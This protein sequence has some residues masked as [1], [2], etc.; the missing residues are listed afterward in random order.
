[1]SNEP[2]P[3]LEPMP[4]KPLWSDDK[5]YK[6]MRTHGL[7]WG[8]LGDG[9]RMEYMTGAGAAKAMLEMREAWQV[10]RRTTHAQL[11]AAEARVK[12]L[13]AELEE[14]T[15]ANRYL[16]SENSML[17]DRAARRLA[18]AKQLEATLAELG[19]SDDD[20]G[21]QDDDR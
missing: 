3:A 12:E 10:D 7:T 1:M 6:C 4:L 15:G 19:W 16:V 18:Y 20:E 11:R 13:E 8:T 2:T 21:G 9:T 17:F 5:I 14:V